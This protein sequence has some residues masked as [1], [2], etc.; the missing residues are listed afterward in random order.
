MARVRKRDWP[1]LVYKYAVAHQTIPEQMWHTARAM[2][3]LWNRLAAG[4]EAVMAAYPKPDKAAADY[5]EKRAARKDAFDRFWETAAGLVKDAPLNWECGPE[6]LDRFKAAVT[7]ANGAAPD[8]VTGKRGYPRVHSG[9]QRICIPH[10]YTGGGSALPLMVSSRARRFRLDTLQAGLVRGVFGLDDAAEI[11]FAAVIHRQIPAGSIV[12]KVMW[13]GER[14]VFGWNWAIAITVEQ[15]PGPP[16]QPTGRHIGIDVGWRR[17]DDTRLRV[18]Y[19]VDSDGQHRELHLP[20]VFASKRVRRYNERHPERRIPTS[21]AELR[22]LQ[23]QGDKRK[24]ACKAA[25]RPLLSPLPPGFAR[26]GRRGLYQLGRELREQQPDHPALAHLVAY[27]DDDRGMHRRYAAAAAHFAARRRWLYEN[28]AA[29][30][31]RTYD[32]I[33]IEDTLRI[34][35]MIEKPKKQRRDGE[36]P[37]PAIEAA[38]RHHQCAA[39]SDMVAILRRAAAKY[40]ATIVAGDTAGTTQ[41]CADC[42]AHIQPGAPR[43]LT[44]ERGHT[45]DQDENAASNLLQQ[46]MQPAVWDARFRAFARRVGRRQPELAAASTE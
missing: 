41:I 38:Q 30:V 20:L 13:L 45:R 2:Q 18:A 22:E 28:W 5:A 11:S 16:R 21:Y 44:C 32:T 19:G 39:T 31:A 6:V 7:R 1:Q 42:G 4:F 14:D 24:D 17:L 3:D 43:V 35:E 8:P 25:I 29:R 23:A 27:Y 12:K 10:R 34:K 15:P 26:M 33:A 40:G 46:I 9:L 36:Q 37:D